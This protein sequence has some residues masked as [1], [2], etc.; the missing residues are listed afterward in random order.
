[1][2][3]TLVT[4]HDLKN[5]DYEYVLEPVRVAVAGRPPVLQVTATFFGNGAGNADARTTVGNAFFFFK[6]KKS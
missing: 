4:T 3:K 2:N 6:K 1:M 5:G